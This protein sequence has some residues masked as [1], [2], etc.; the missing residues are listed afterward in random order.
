[1]PSQ[2]LLIELQPH[3]YYVDYARLPSALTSVFLPSRES[4]VLRTIDLEYIIQLGM[5]VFVYGSVKLFVQIFI[6]YDLYNFRP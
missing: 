4:G 3:N 6:G 2:M 1:M 5:V